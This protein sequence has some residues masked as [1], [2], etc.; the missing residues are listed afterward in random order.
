LRKAG[1]PAL[2]P[3]SPMPPGGSHAFHDMHL[4]LRDLAIRSMR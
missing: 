2:A 4:D 1:G 3:V